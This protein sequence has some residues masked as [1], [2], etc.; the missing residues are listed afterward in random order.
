MLFQLLAA[1]PFIC[2]FLSMCQFMIW[3]H[4]DD[5]TRRHLPSAVGMAEEGWALR[6]CISKHEVRLKSRMNSP[7]FS[8]GH[9][10]SRGHA[11]IRQSAAVIAVTAVEV[12][13]DFCW[14]KVSGRLA[15]D[16]DFPSCASL[17]A[18]HQSEDRRVEC[19]GI[20]R[21]DFTHLNTVD[22]RLF[23]EETKKAAVGTHECIVYIV[24]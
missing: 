15:K 19:W 21:A 2:E 11:L 1:L 6:L 8:Q 20:V 18:C 7:L 9:R 10:I 14:I 17:R 12:K 23:W 13:L 16:P 22:F 4:C 3:K 24:L 5:E